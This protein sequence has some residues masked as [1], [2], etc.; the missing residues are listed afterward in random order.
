MKRNLVAAIILAVALPA[1]YAATNE[2]AKVQ[3]GLKFGEGN[4]KAG[5]AV[6]ISGSFK[7]AKTPAVAAL[8]GAEK[9]SSPVPE[10]KPSTA[11]PQGFIDK[12]WEFTAD[13]KAIGLGCAGALAGFL[14]GGPAGAAIGF[15]AMFLIRKFAA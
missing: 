1:A 9:T 2:Q 15:A 3:S 6:E 10:V 11:A 13:Q 12:A 5:S 4:S 8:K 14:M 7:N